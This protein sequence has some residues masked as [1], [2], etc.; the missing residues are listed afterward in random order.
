M[1][2]RRVHDVDG[3]MPTHI[4]YICRC[5]SYN[6]RFWAKLLGWGSSFALYRLLCRP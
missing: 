2:R 4:Q 3:P 1:T 6:F 5:R